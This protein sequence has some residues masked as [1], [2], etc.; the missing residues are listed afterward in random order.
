[1]A[2]KPDKKRPSKP[3]GQFPK[4][5]GMK[6]EVLEPGRA[7]Y[8][9]KISKKFLNRLDAVHGGAIY[10]LIDHSMGGA[11]YT[12]LPRNHLCATIE[13]ITHYFEAVRSGELWVETRVVKMGKR[14]AHLKSEVTHHPSGN[15][16]AAALGTFAIF[17][18]SKSNKQKDKE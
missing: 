6:L 15:K 13:I 10:A 4:M 14:I 16:V 17:T 9:M 12:S 8:S 1:M 18:S 7:V 2:V 5:F 3:E 11:I